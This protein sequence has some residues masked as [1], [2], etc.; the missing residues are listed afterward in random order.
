[1]K[2]K[3][4]IMTILCMCTGSAVQAVQLLL[5]PVDSVIPVA[6]VQVWLGNAAIFINNVNAMDICIKNDISGKLQNLKNVPSDGLNISLSN[7]K[8][9][10]KLTTSML[11]CGLNLINTCP[12]YDNKTVAITY[13]RLNKIHEDVGLHCTKIDDEL[14]CRQELYEFEELPPISER[15]KKELE[16]CLNFQK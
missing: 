15:G 4:I 1:M 16:S 13:F 7:C 6:D 12:F 9:I 3:I 2:Y 10:Y 11:K 5:T 8:E 14:K